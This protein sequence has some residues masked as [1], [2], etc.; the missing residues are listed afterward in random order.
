MIG[1]LTRRIMSATR[2]PVTTAAFISIEHVNCTFN[3][4]YAETVFPLICI[5]VPESHITG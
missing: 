5:C 4:A 1:R 3:Y 2:T